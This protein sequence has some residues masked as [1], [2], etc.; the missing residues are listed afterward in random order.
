MRLRTAVFL[1]VLSGAFYSSVSFCQNLPS[2]QS[3]AAAL[4]VISAPAIKSY[5]DHSIRDIE[6]VGDRNVGCTRGFGNWYSL[7]HQIAMG[8]QYSQQ[9]E[10]TVKLIQDPVVTEYVNRLGQN[11]VRNSD[12]KV[13]FTIKVLDTEEVNAFA[14]PGGFFFVWTLWALG[15]LGGFTAILSGRGLWDLRRSRPR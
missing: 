10:S 8:K 14:L 11:L 5:H 12:A 4:D 6:A 3:E 1:S 9:V 15:G 7:E 13:P 2:L